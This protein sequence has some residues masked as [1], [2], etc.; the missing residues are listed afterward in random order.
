MAAAR[1]STDSRWRLL[2]FHCIAMSVCAAASDEPVTGGS[3]GSGTA[4]SAAE[5]LASGVVAKVDKVL[6]ESSGGLTKQIENLKKAQQEARKAR[7]QLSRDLRNAQRRKR[8]LKAKSRMLSVDDL[9]D[10]LMMRKEAT[11][12]PPEAAKLEPFA[13]PNCAEG[14]GGDDD[15]DGDDAP[16]EPKAAKIGE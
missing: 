4:G 12:A 8:R 2:A 15:E 6:A 5:P 14:A 3:S 1:A 13:V 9:V 11:T 10:V 7:Q 16:P